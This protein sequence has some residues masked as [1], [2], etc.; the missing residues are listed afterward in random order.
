VHFLAGH[1]VAMRWLNAHEG[2]LALKLD[3]AFELGGLATGAM[4]ITGVGR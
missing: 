1:E 3:D 4:S 2:N